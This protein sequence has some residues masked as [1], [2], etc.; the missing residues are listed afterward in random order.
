MIKPRAFHILVEYCAIEL[1][2]QASYF[3][4]IEQIISQTL[5]TRQKQD[6]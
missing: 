4:L 1:Y 2:L 5:K 3:T 6:I